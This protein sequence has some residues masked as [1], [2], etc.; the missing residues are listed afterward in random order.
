MHKETS[1]GG[2]DN[3]V[4]GE[5]AEGMKGEERKLSTCSITLKEC[6]PNYRR[7]EFLF[8]FCKRM[9]ALTE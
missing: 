8:S 1:T 2:M 7:T 3:K 4:E 5:K 6:L 9:R